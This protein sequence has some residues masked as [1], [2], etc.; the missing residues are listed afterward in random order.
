MPAIL[1][2]G[3]RPGNRK[4]STPHGRCCRPAATLLAPELI[5]VSA[6]P[7]V[8]GRLDA[9]AGYRTRRAGG[10]ADWLLILT[11]H[12]RGVV[13]AAEAGPVSAGPGSFITIAPGTPHDY[14]TAPDAEEW[15]L[16]WAH[17][18]PRPDWL[19]LLDG[20]RTAS[21]VGRVLLPAPVVPRVTKALEPA[22]SLSGSG[23]T[24]A[25]LFGLNAVEEALLWCATQN[26]R[27]ERTDPRLLDVLEHLGRHLAAPHAVRSLADVAGL[28]PS[29]LTR[30]FS[31]RFGTGVMTHVEERRMEVAGR[32]LRLSALPVREVAL[33]VGYRD[34]LYFSTRFKRATGLSPSAYRTA[35]GNPE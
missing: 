4:T 32:L 27:G 19:P 18:R 1:C 15:S 29:R 11:R 34:P 31:A 10:T 6:R 7:I 28:S 26:P 33:H 25:T 22:V 35:A 3:S 8:S 21:G 23:L 24:H 9:R 5:A 17:I 12:G 30:L 20:P 16:L 2:A 14:G 13:R